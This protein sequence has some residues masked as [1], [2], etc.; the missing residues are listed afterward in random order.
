[1]STDEMDDMERP[2]DHEPL[3]WLFDA[4]ALSAAQRP[5]SFDGL[6]NWAAA[7][8]YQRQEAMIARLGELVVKASRGQRALASAFLYAIDFA[9]VEDRA[10]ADV[11]G[12]SSFLSDLGGADSA[13][14]EAILCLLASKSEGLV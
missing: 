14:L 8:E 9:H 1:M 4:L 5:D 13:H 6:L 10:R 3:C 2:E 11:P 12:G 7:M